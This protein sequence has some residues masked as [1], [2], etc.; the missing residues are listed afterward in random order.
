MFTTMRRIRQVWFCILFLTYFKILHYF[1]ITAHIS[2]LISKTPSPNVP[3]K[4]A[5]NKR[6]FFPPCR[7]IYVCLSDWYEFQCFWCGEKFDALL[8]ACSI[9]LWRYWKIISGATLFTLAI[10]SSIQ[11]NPFWFMWMVI[12]RISSKRCFPYL[13]QITGRWIN[14]MYFGQVWPMSIHGS[15]P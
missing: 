7:E 4:W 8:V 9:V 6:I 13:E 2:N 15:H 5:L 3:P 1:L 12:S 11:F 10:V 14:V